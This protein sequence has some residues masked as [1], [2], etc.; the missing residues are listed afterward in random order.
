MS[1]ETTEIMSIVSNSYECNNMTVIIAYDL[2]GNDLDSASVPS[3]TDCSVWCR[4]NSSRVASTWV[5]LTRSITTSRCYRK[6][7][8]SSPSYTGTHISAYN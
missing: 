2:Y 5:L 4:T 3:Y 1:P 6:K 7:N 8:I